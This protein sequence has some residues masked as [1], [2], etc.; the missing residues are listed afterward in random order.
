MLRCGSPLKPLL[1]LD[2]MAAAKLA[3][4]LTWPADISCTT[5]SST[6]S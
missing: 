3:G 4:I 2:M 6:C 1:S 5:V